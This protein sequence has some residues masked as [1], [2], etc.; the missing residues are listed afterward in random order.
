MTNVVVDNAKIM[1]KG[2]ITLPSKIRS[3][4]GVGAGDSV[5]LISDGDKVIMMNAAVYAMKML[6]KEMEGE[7]A[8]ADLATEDAVDSFVKE[9]R[10]EMT[11][12]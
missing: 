7:A 8:A 12:A 6:Q 4:L 5:A 11:S 3:A 2:Q 9:I 1:P 10:A